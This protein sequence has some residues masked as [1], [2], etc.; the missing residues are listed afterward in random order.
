MAS[1]AELFDL[2]PDELHP[3]IRHSDFS[4]MVMRHV[5][6]GRSTMLNSLRS[7]SGQ[8]FEM[9]QKCFEKGY[10]READTK[11]QCSIRVDGKYA[12]LPPLLLPEGTKMPMPKSVLFPSRRLALM[13]RVMLNGMRSGHRRRRS[14]DTVGAGAT[15]DGGLDTMA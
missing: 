1:A 13:V 4:K 15:S 7:V 5:N 11:M 14:Q 6:N 10:N 8:I 3:F 2:L 9:D 12:R